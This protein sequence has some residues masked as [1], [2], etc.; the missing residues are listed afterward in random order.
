MNHDERLKEREL[1]KVKEEKEKEGGKLTRPK[2]ME[3]EAKSVF[4]SKSLS[5][6][7]SNKQDAASVKD[8]AQPVSPSL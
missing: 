4:K 3:P 5:E 6:K 7:P 1:V 8:A 2:P